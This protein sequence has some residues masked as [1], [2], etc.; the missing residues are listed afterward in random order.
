MFR[1][2]TI[3]TCTLNYKQWTTAPLQLRRMEVWRDYIPLGGSFRCEASPFPDV[4]AM[5]A[6]PTP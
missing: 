1:L 3:E 4:L 6:C 2:N 5:T